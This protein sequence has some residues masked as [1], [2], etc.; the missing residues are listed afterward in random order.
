MSLFRIFYACGFWGDEIASD[1]AH[2]A[3]KGAA[4]AAA[5]GTA[6]ARIIPAPRA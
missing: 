6:V 5:N 4:I 2:A 1:A 3:S